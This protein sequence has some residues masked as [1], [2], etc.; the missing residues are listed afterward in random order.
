MSVI[1]I[2]LEN[3][4]KFIQETD[5]NEEIN[6][7]PEKETMTIVINNSFLFREK[8]KTIKSKKYLAFTPGILPIKEDNCF[9]VSGL[10]LKKDYIIIPKSDTKIKDIIAINEAILQEEKS[11][12]D[13]V[14]V[15]MGEIDEN[16]EIAENVNHELIN[17][18]IYSPKGNKTVNIN[19]GIIRLNSIDNE[20]DNW[21]FIES[22]LKNETKVDSE[23]IN[24]LKSVIG[25]LFDNLKKEA[26]LNLRIPDKYM[27][28]KKYFLELITESIK[29][30]IHV[31]ENCIK[32]IESASSDR[33]YTFNEIL[34]I[35][36]NFAD[37]ASTLIRLLVSVCDLKPI[38]L[39]AT[40]FSHYNLTESI[41]NL[42]RSRQVTK[43]SINSYIET[44]KKARNK[45]FH[46]LIP[47]SKAFEVELPPNSIKN[48]S[49][50]IFSEYG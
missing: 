44:I 30:Q 20:D 18:I 1:S 40:F 43:P 11:L 48:A 21:S 27:T 25:S 33:Q 49:S 39:W 24:N 12:G 32:N 38:I 4:N 17:K 3:I 19:D 10:E 29:E 35:S 23:T 14:F 22:Y 28:D 8:I 47:F 41:R 9:V 26:F 50:R 15:L 5:L 2:I 42:P 34:R 45:T 6:R 31:Y 36:Y 13:I 46:R 16:L 37:D 7:L